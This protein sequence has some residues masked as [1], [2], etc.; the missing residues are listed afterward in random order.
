M[1]VLR[2]TL[3]AYV[4]AIT[5]F[6]AAEAEAAQAAAR[7]ALLRNEYQEAWRKVAAFRNQ[8]RLKPGSY[9]VHDKY[10]MIQSV[11]DYPEPMPGFEI[12]EDA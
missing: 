10:V 12:R 1:S 11:G 5:E 9:R 7:L 4:R 2:L 3:E 6:R 8:G